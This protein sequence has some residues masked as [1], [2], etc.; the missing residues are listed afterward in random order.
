MQDVRSGLRETVRA[1][2]LYGVL[3]IALTWPMAARLHVM[4]AGDSAFFAWEMAWEIHALRTDPGQLPHA[5][6]FHPLQYTLGMDEPVLGT[7]LLALPL[8]WATDDAIWIFNV[9]R[10]LTFALSGLSAYALARELGGGEKAALF[11]GTAFAFALIRTTPIAHLS[12]LGTQWLPLVVL[13]LHR[14]QRTARARDAWLAGLFFVLQTFAC[15]YHGII[16]TAVL[17]LAA[18]PLFWRRPA[19]VL[20]AVPAMAAAV[21]ALWPLYCLHRAGLAP[22]GYVRGLDE[23][24][25]YSA[26]LETFLSAPAWSR[27]YGPLTASFRGA[28]NDLFLGLTCPGLILAGAYRTWKDRRRVD[29]AAWSLAVMMATAALFAL[30]PEIR[31]FGRALCPGPFAALRSAVPLFQMIRVPSRA[32]IFLALGASMLAARAL[33]RWEGRRVVVL[34]AGAFAVAESLIVPVPLP[35]W[36]QVIDT[37]EPPPPVYEWLAAQP[38]RVPVVE[39]PILEDRGIHEQPAQH[40]SIYMV[41]STR[42]W[43]PLLNGYAGLEP[44]AYVELREKARRFPSPDSLE[45]MRRLGARYVIVHRRGYG[46]FKRARLE[47]D[48]ALGADGLETVGVFG[49]DVVLALG[50]R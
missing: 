37:R 47:R 9:V 42:H 40:E 23:T 50:P 3:A 12:T 5:N 27:L 1:L 48:L 35:G 7:T 10:L 6:I 45:V 4:D 8:S 31:L 16:G 41:H 38:G 2:A 32:G 15:G 36:A 46:P 30:G 29:A 24:V 44:P 19:L 18:L 17:P 25:H 26:S 43:K 14:Y 28:A 11:G 22:L 20:R 21:L 39:L 13:F 34:A 49:D 33:G